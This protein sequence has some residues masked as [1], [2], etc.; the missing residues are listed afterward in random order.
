MMFRK[1]AALTLPAALLLL[2]PAVR[3]EDAKPADAVTTATANKDLEPLKV[4]LPKP[5]FIGTPKNISSPN[6]E[7]QT[8]KP[9]PPLMVAKGSVLLSK[10]KAVTGSDKEPVVGDLT[11]I[12]D[13]DK[14][15]GDGTYVELGPGKQWVQIDLGQEAAIAA[16][17]MWHFH[18]EGRVYHDVVVQISNDPDFVTGVTTVFNNDHDNSS[19]LGVGK[20]KEYIETFEGRPVDGKNTKGRYV[21]LYSKGNTSS[22]ENNY[23]EVEVYGKPAK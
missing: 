10:G 2:A 16:V 6:L 7:P 15:G 23:V 14:S 18:N 12:T 19:G 9:R 13:G 11:L 4:E 22:D 1:I 3:A 5:L 21:R 20:D 17:V 8:G